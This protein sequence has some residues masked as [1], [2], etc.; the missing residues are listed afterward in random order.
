MVE[1]PKLFWVFLR[2]LFL[3]C[4]YQAAFCLIKIKVK[5]REGISFT[6]PDN[7]NLLHGCPTSLHTCIYKRI[8]ST[9]G[10]TTHCSRHWV[11]FTLLVAHFDSIQ[12]LNKK[13]LMTEKT[14]FFFL[15][16]Y[17]E[18]AD[19]LMN[20]WLKCYSSGVQKT[21]VLCTITHWPWCNPML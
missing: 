15:F 9:W 6:A 10:V 5:W 17:H 19:H 21:C 3:V 4:R 16:L 8:N 2:T 13:I 11:W 7:E 1:A 14:L 12:I 18:Q 20:Y